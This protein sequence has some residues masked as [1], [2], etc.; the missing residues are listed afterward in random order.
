M[1]KI[2]C[3]A[4]ISVALAGCTNS[5][6][7]WMPE[8]GGEVVLGID[9]LSLSMETKAI[10]DG[11]AGTAGSGKL[12][13]IGV[14]VTK[15]SAGSMTI[16]SAGTSLTTFTT[17]DGKAW[18]TSTPIYLNNTVGTVYA[19]VPYTLNPTVAASGDHTVSGVN[20]S[21]S[22]TFNAANTWECNQEDYLYG[23]SNNTTGSTTQPT[24]SKTSPTVT[25][26]YL[27]HALAK[28]SFKIMKANGQTLNT[29][30]YVKKIVLKSAGNKFV[31]GSGK[32][33]NIHTGAI[34]GAAG[35]GDLTLAPSGYG[36]AACKQL[37]A[38]A[39]AYAGVDV[40]AYGLVAP[41]ASASSDLTVELTLGPNAALNA[42]TDRT[43]TNTT[44]ANLQWEKG[45]HYTY[46]IT[47]TD[48]ALVISNVSVNAWAD[49][50]AV[51]VPVQ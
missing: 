17:S 16:Y 27:Q 37:S 10:Y 29:D 33:M 3:L 2:I 22:Q 40:K 18:A 13:S 15:G 47:V 26:F 31:F 41:V 8:N 19:W 42:A 12:N 14:L 24:A 38:Y 43:Y 48:A 23:T 28:V 25:N 36:S 6:T 32:T 21:Q 39:A 20:V 51:D 30:D 50:P 7:D 34:S 4:V 49:Q 9:K 45:K 35:A 46:T 11:V 5:E 1:K 44:K